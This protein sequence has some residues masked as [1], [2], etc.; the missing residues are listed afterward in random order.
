MDQFKETALWILSLIILVILLWFTF[1]IVNIIVTGYKCRKLDRTLSFCFNTTGK[2]VY[3]IATIVYILG[4]FGGIGYMIYAAMNGDNYLFRN[5]L[6]V[7]AFVSVVY[8]YLLSSIVMVGKKNLMV[9]R[10]MIDYRKL[11]KVNYT[12]TN[13]MS[14]VY[15]QQ[16]YSFSTRFVDKTVLRKAISR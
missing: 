9:G 12:Y 5:A 10:M 13:K 8:G 3:S 7:A 16:D 2:I 1:T 6:N 14:F 11:K 15:A 4:F